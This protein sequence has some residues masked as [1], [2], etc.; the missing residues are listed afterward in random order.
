MRAVM[1]FISCFKCGRARHLVRDC[2]QRSNRESCGPRG[3]A[4]ECRQRTALGT[5]EQGSS[6][7]AVCDVQRSNRT[8]LGNERQGPTRN[9]S[10][11]QTKR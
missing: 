4:E 9:K 7:E 2:R 6:M 3:Q 10:R 11:P 1:S 5:R 8:Q